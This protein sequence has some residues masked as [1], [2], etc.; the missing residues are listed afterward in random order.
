MEYDLNFEILSIKFDLYSGYNLDN[1]QQE[2]LG[3]I[4]TLLSG[5]TLSWFALLLKKNS[6]LIK[7]LDDFFTKFN[8]TFGKTDRVRTATTKFCSLRQ[9]SRPA[10]IYV[11]DFR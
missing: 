8:D 2:Y 6:L 1:I 4:V 11:A 7:D 9:E 5:A 10:S 3:L